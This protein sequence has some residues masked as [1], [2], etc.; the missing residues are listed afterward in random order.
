MTNKNEIIE[1]TSFD[2][3]TWL[4]AS[5][6]KKAEMLNEISIEE[7]A[8]ILDLY[9]YRNLSTRFDVF[10]V[11]IRISNKHILELSTLPDIMEEMLEKL[12]PL[13]IE[14]NELKLK[15]NFDNMLK[16]VQDLKTTMKNTLSELKEL[17]LN[18]KETFEDKAK[19]TKMIKLNS[20]LIDNCKQFKYNTEAFLKLNNKQEAH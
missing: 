20:Q 3:Y 8:T 2:L 19:I 13:T 1:Q 14:V 10:N 16:N 7:R 15:E 9:I 11:L 18:P 4:D 12:M 5:V 17:V 6:E